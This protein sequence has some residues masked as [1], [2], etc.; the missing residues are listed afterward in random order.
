MGI[1]IS[2]STSI[3]GKKF[4][5]LHKLSQS[6]LS[7]V[8]KKRVEQKVWFFFLFRRFTWTRQYQH[9]KNPCIAILNLNC[10]GKTCQQ[11]VI[12]AFLIKIRSPCNAI[13]SRWWSNNSLHRVY[14]GHPSFP[15]W[16][17][18]THP[19]SFFKGT[20]W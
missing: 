18:E 7:G 1:Y 3:K 9:F 6:V 8:I 10:G 20:C 14:K 11:N 4:L 5:T 19:S 17:N 13:L 16:Y 2:L 12:S 15:M